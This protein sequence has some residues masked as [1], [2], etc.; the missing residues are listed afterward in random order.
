MVIFRNDQVVIENTHITQYSVSSVVVV[1][2]VD[3]Q[4]VAGGGFR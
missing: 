3:A 2:L 4:L 1:V